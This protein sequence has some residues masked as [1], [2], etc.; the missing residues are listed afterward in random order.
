[1]NEEQNMTPEDVET[2]GAP[3]P[4]T[5]DADASGTPNDTYHAVDHAKKDVISNIGD[6]E[7]HNEGLVGTGEVTTID[8][9]SSTERLADEQDEA[10]LH[11]NE[12]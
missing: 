2:S 9:H 12:G 3:S 11:D 5:T 10:E 7:M 6:G 4:A 1:M 8:L